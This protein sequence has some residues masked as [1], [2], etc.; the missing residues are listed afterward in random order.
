MVIHVVKEGD[1]ILSVANEYG[2]SPE[3]LTADNGL[4]G[5]NRPVIGQALLILQPSETYTVREGDTIFSISQR[6]GITPERLKQKNPSLAQTNTIIPGE[7]LTITFDGEENTPIE[8]YGFMYPNIKDNILNQ[9]LPSLWG[10]AI[11]SYGVREDGGLIPVNDS[12]LINKMLQSRVN[13]YMVLSSIDETGGFSS[14]N[15]ARLFNSEALQNTA[16]NNILNTMRQKGYRGLDI[17]FEFV[18]PEDRDAFADFVENITERLNQ[19]GFMVN[20]DLAPKTS[21][22]QRGTLY[23]GHDYEDIGEASNTVMVMTYEWGY[24]YS[25]P[26][27]VA[28][29]DKVR[30]VLEYAVSRIPR[31]KIY[32]GMPNYGYDWKLPYEKGVT[33]ARL[34]GNEEAIA[35]AAENNAEIQ[36]DERSQSPYF[37]Y[38]SADGTNH[39]VWFEDIRSMVAKYNLLNELG[40][41]GA[42]FWNL[43]RSFNQNWSYIA[44]RYNPRKLA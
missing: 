6:F 7:V 41:R 20:T 36:F 19:N 23:E 42:G 24:T 35:I 11:F 4:Y 3:R 12:E 15:A 29:I 14:G 34:I 9:S 38:Q 16:I 37:T 1:S 28:P 27:A 22:N 17:D 33:R 2:I 25:E 13:P 21:D 30:E 40:L 5:L 10:G 44:Y 43:M 31:D 39:E 8:I 32:M 26:M 18:N